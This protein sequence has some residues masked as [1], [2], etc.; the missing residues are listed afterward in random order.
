MG[1]P[2]RSSLAVLNRTV[3]D[4]LVEIR[5]KKQTPLLIIDEAHL[6][7][8]EVF[9]QLHSLT[10][11]QFDS[12]NLMPVVLA[13]QNSLLDKLLFHTSRPLASR[14]V[15]R[16]YL[17]ALKLEDMRGYLLHHH[18]LA[19]CTDNLFSDEAIVAI[20]Q[21]SGGLLRRANHL[22]RGAL[23]AGVRENS[24]VISA[25]HVRVASTEIL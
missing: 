19:G 16:S 25:E 8:F 20:H 17:E 18:Q 10:Q 14:V 7:R 22:A 24:S 1:S 2:A 23:M 5:S 12:Q 21:G 4:L 15:G 3:R 13:G 11:F 6:L 9:A